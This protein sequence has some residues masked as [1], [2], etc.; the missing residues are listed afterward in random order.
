MELKLNKHQI[1]TALACIRITQEQLKTTIFDVEDLMPQH[2]EDGAEACDLDELS[3]ALNTSPQREQVGN[4]GVDAGLC[5][6]GDPCYILP[7]DRTENVG[8]DWPDF[9]RKIAGRDHY[10]FDYRLGHEGVGVCVSTGWGDGT[11]P[12]YIE[13]G[14]EGRIASATVVFM[15]D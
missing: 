3:E 14:E 2:F 1:A 6:I 13:R 9:C 10:S 5:W 15:R 7:E 12:V 11:Y 8:K 4:I